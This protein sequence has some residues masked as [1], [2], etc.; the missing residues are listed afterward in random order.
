M[1]RLGFTAAVA[2]LVAL[3]P[4][5]REVAHAQP[6][7]PRLRQQIEQRFDVLPLRNG[8]LALHPKVE[9]GRV[10]SIEIGEGPIAIDGAPATGAELREKLGRDADLVLRL[11]YLDRDARQRL[12]AGSA[13]PAE[14]PEPSVS[15]QPSPLPEPPPP[16]EPPSPP[17][18]PRP[19]ARPPNPNP[20]LDPFSRSRRRGRNGGDRVRFGGN[21]TV[22]EGEEV[23]GDAV[24]IGGSV[25]INGRVSGDAVSV[26]GSLML[27]PHA[28]VD[29]DA[30]VIGGSLKRDP[31]ARVG[32]KVVDVGAGN[33]DFGS[34]RWDRWPPFGRF[35]PFA[36]AM[37]GL[38]AFMST[39]ARVAI[40]CV[41][42]C[43]VLLLGREYVERVS[44]RAA[45]EPVKAGAIGVLAQLLFIPLLI[46]TIV[47]LVVTIIGIPLLVLIPFAILGLAV[48]ALVG[49]T[50]VAYHLGRLV[51]QRFAW[52]LHN[53]YMTVTTGVV[54]LISPVL[55]ARLLG[56]ANWLMFPITGALL[57]VGV[58]AEYLAWT[59]GF[60]AV[61]LL[62]F[63]RPGGPPP[64]AQI[65]ST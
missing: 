15:T 42:A 55:I 61:A 34:W 31:G 17:E 3:S 65:V 43:L 41:L 56:L 8:S 13:L 63:S 28:D 6:V 37:G 27:G 32:G 19:S 11:S 12:F 23:R 36:G 40:L 62:R 44:V 16:P 9:Q 25:N 24:A 54:L 51:N 45:A 49:F 29:G 60:G 59:V 30:V 64:T 58:L 50:A 2:A 52:T 20:D 33:F 10:K 38:F 1:K 14:R 53:P 57:F 35:F 21:V 26:G 5:G 39:I 47:V 7:D 22:Q 4:C 48:I 46:A 18:S